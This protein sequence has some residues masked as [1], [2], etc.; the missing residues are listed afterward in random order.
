MNRTK[1]VA[2][3][4]PSTHTPEMIA[5]LLKAGV[6]VFRLN[7]SHGDHEGHATVARAVRQASERARRPAGILC[8]LCGP[9]IRIGPISPEPVVLHNGDT[10]TLT[11]LPAEGT[12]QRVMVN[13]PGMACDVREGEHI[14][15]DDG[16]LMFEIRAVR[17]P[18]IEC[19]V[20]RG[21]P[22]SSH[23]GINL[24]HT[25]LRISPM[26][27]KDKADIDFGLEHDADFF[28][29]SFVQRAA[30]IELFREYMK[31]KGGNL[32]LI[33][34][35][36]MAEAVRNLDEILATA[37]GAMV[38]RGDLGVEI[39][40]EEVPLAQKRIIAMCNRLAKPVITATQMLDSMI[41]NPRPTRAEVC[42]IANAIFDGTD[43]V[44][45]SGETA[46][47]AYPLESVEMMAATA[48]AAEGG[49]E[50][51]K[52]LDRTLVSAHGTV[53]D[54]ISRATA[55]IAD[56]L[57]LD[58][59]LCLSLSGGTAR[60]VARYRPCS[61]ILTYSLSRRTAQQLCLIWGVRALSHEHSTQPIQAGDGENLETQIRRAV[62]LFKQ[63]G[64]LKSGE[65]VAIT[66]GLPL[67]VSGATNLLHVAE[68]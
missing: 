7:M 28:A 14:L 33:A 46:S 2:T 65:H 9:K 42:D 23:K 66:V 1:I 45:L 26:T 44:M 63:Y 68:V 48:A 3:I 19:V 25:K 31:S 5:A 24:P 58:H 29:V 35:I 41:R 22:L 54:S 20:L 12:A 36:E 10:I 21:G 49:L 4:G 59:I 15:L 38:A 50:H 34:K 27:D 52:F 37:D 8:D 56:D 53:P 40:I 55:K 17:P 11:T 32:P 6:D 64:L 13:Y 16:L 18:D 47:G 67:N 39:P 43:A 61:E 30:D 60:L 57:N 51:A 62:C